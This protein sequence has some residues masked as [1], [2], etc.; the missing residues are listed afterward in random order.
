MRKDQPSK[1]TPFPSPSKQTDARTFGTGGQARG[2]A[3]KLVAGQ[4]PSVPTTP[5]SYAVWTSSGPV[6]QCNWG[7]Q[8]GPC[9][10]IGQKYFW[11]QLNIGIPG[12]VFIQQ[13]FSKKKN[14]HSGLSVV[15]QTKRQKQ[16]NKL[17]HDCAAFANA[18][19]MS[20]RSRSN[21]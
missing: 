9:R 10:F 15:N 13:L 11:L 20:S 8:A 14:Y 5:N 18:F 21:S 12:T 17:I 4:K 2:G 3:T 6:T 16:F 7:P 1:D 19:L